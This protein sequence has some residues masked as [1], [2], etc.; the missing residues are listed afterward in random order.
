ME[1]IFPRHIRK[2]SL[3]IKTGGQILTFMGHFCPRDCRT[4]ERGHQRL[5]PRL[6]RLVSKHVLIRLISLD[7]SAHSVIVVCDALL[8]AC[9]TV[10]CRKNACIDQSATEDDQLLERPGVEIFVS[11][12][13]N[14]YRLFR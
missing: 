5:V 9:V 13:L 3:K 4:I 7:S 10:H 11:L 2:I 8:L 14:R 12:K 6:I 1:T